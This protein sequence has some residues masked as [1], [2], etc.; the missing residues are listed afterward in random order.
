MQ[1]YLQGAASVALAVLE[2]EGAA[3]V[4][5]THLLRIAGAYASGVVRHTAGK[6]R[7]RG[8]APFPRAA[9]L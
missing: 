8:A 9:L 4:L 3:C 7:A 6:V 5:G 1:A 2:A